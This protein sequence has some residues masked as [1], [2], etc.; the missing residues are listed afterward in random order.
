MTYI[1]IPVL[2]NRTDSIRRSW[3]FII[4][5]GM[6]A[7]LMFIFLLYTATLNSL[8]L[9]GLLLLY[10]TNMILFGG[11]LIVLEMHFKQNS[12]YFDLI[13]PLVGSVYL[14]FFLIEFYLLSNLYYM[15]ILG[16]PH[17]VIAG[18]QALVWTV[19]IG[20]FKSPWKPSS[21]NRENVSLEF[22]S[23]YWNAWWGVSKAALTL[24]VSVGIGFAIT[25]AIQSDTFSYNLIG[26][27]V[28]LTTPPFLLMCL[29]IG[30]RYRV[31]VN[32]YRDTD[33]QS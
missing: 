10:V 5:F 16:N 17:S 33:I 18:E 20:M 14:P 12:S 11:G 23:S 8:P 26:L 25:A 19:F 29:F 24:I 7:P 2:P 21:L 15:K 3:V 1:D 4:W 27:H 13:L 9:S 28:L 22:L 32:N 31:I 30:H 6:Y